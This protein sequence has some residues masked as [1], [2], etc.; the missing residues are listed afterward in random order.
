[1]VR[2]RPTRTTTINS[3]PSTAAGIATNTQ[4]PTAAETAVDSPVAGTAPINLN[5]PDGLPSSQG[6]HHTVDINYFFDTNPTDGY[7][8]CRSCL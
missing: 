7:Q 5:D 1:M 2:A 3:P 4:P 8:T 6:V